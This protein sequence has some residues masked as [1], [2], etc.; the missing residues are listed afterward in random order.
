MRFWGYDLNVRN[1]SRSP[2]QVSVIFYKQMIVAICILNILFN[3][4]S[5]HYALHQL[6]IFILANVFDMKF[7]F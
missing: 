7:P 4:L 1:D 5:V 2:V 3:V 6:I